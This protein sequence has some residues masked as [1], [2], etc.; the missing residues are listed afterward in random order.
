MKYLV[1]TILF[2]IMC[3]WAVGTWESRV[4]TVMSDAWRVEA[5]C[6]TDAEC[7]D[8]YGYNEDFMRLED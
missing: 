5:L 1:W 2:I 4:I 8:R 7:Q 3:L 6:E